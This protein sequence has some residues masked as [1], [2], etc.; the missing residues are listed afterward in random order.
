MDAATHLCGQ[1][2]WTVLVGD[3]ISVVINTLD[4]HFLVIRIA[5]FKPYFGRFFPKIAT[6]VESRWKD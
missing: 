6:G 1:F 5:V 4:V 3:L 2:W